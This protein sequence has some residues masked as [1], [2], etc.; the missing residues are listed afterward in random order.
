MKIS[1]ELLMSQAKAYGIR[2]FYKTLHDDLLGEA[3]AET[4]TI[5]LDVSLLD[6]PRSL[7]CVLAEE[8]GHIVH[9][10]RPGHIR[11]HSRG[12]HRREDYSM[13]KTTVA[14]DERKARDW[15]TSVLIP[16]VEFNR[17][18]ANGDYSLSELMEYYDVEQW[19]LEHK[20]SYYRRKERNKGRKVKWRDLI[21]RW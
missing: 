11:Y 5:T 15:A 20:I 14:Q 13:I 6:N 10:P 2:V 7:K 1:L 3:N 17:M 4:K 21:R 9:P 12:F 19:F 18:V 16:D 8:I